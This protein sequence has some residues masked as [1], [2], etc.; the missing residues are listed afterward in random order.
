MLRERVDALQNE[1]VQLSEMIDELSKAKEVNTAVDS[2]A[3]VDD[4]GAHESGGQWFYR[5]VNFLTTDGV[6]ENELMQQY[7]CCVERQCLQN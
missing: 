1:T 4:H 7:E 6:C 3:H 5:C 2:T